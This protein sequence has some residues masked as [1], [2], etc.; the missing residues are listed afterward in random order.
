MGYYAT[1][2]EHEFKLPVRQQK[3]ILSDKLLAEQERVRKN[4]QRFYRNAKADFK[5]LVRNTEVLLAQG[6]TEKEIK[7]CISDCVMAMNMYKD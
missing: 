2:E 4:R 5:Q 7:R 6:Y 3:K 1:L